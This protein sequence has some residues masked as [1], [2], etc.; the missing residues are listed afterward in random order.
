MKKLVV[1]L[2]V[3]LMIAGSIGAEETGSRSFV[4]Q[5]S[6]VEGYS[7]VTINKAALKILSLVAKAAG[8]AAE[9]ELALFSRIDGIQVLSCPAKKDR[10]DTFEGEILGFCETNGYES[11]LKCEESGEVVHI[12]CSLKDDAV[13][14]FTIWS[15][16]GGKV[17][18][19][20]LNGRFTA[21]DIRNVMDKRGKNLGL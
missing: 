10:A 20:F 8:G 15:R 14:G 12:Y 3:F 16:K 2:G 7:V 4:K 11:I 1:I 18:V 13:T 19:I 21:D 9:E 17:N 5:Y 6:G